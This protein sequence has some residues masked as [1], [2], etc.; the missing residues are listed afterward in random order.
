MAT[1]KDNEKHPPFVA[2][3]RGFVGGYDNYGAADAVVQTNGNGCVY[4]SEHEYAK[5]EA[6]RDSLRDP[7]KY[8]AWCR[9]INHGQNEYGADIVTVETCDSDA[10]GAFKVYC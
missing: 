7:E 8:V 10:E 5:L 3:G 4:F 9:Y 1:T 2:F 6:E